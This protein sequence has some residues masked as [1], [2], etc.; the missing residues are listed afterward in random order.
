MKLPTTEQIADWRRL[1]PMHNAM[2]D[3]Y[4][5]RQAA[6][7]ATKL[8]KRW[9]TLPIERGPLPAHIRIG[10]RI[11]AGATIAEAASREYLYRWNLA[12][13]SPIFGAPHALGM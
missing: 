6:D 8:F 1:G 5:N 12:L 13:R 3:Y 9:C 4:E 7:L 2:A 10:A 11:A